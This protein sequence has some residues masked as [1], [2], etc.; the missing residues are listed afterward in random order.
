MSEVH[1]VQKTFFFFRNG[2]IS[3]FT[4]I[5]NNLSLWF[6]LLKRT[7]FSTS[8]FGSVMIGRVVSYQNWSKV[9][10]AS[11]STWPWDGWCITADIRLKSWLFYWKEAGSTGCVTVNCVHQVLWG[12]GGDPWLHAGRVGAGLCWPQHRTGRRL[13]LLRLWRIPGEKIKAFSVSA[14]MFLF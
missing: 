8:F 2:F 10:T 3:V 5:K 1:S 12:G 4:Q 9:E 13:Q 7:P 14:W 6:V 11:S